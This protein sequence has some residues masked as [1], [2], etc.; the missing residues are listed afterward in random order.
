MSVGIPRARTDILMASSELR[1]RVNDFAIRCFRDTAD[2]DYIAAR[3]ACRARLLSQ[4]LWASQQAI[5]KYLKCILLLKRIPPAD[6]KHDLDKAL[7]CLAN[8]DARVELCKPTQEFIRYLDRYGRFR[9]LEISHWGRGSDLLILDRAV[10]EVRRHCTL[11]DIGP[12]HQLV[13]GVEGANNQAARRLLGARYRWPRQAPWFR[14]F[15]AAVAERV[16]W[17][18][19]SKIPATGRLET[20]ASPSTTPANIFVSST[21]GE[22]AA[23]FTA[24]QVPDL[25][26]R[27]APPIRVRVDDLARRRHL[28]AAAVRALGWLIGLRLD[29]ASGHHDT[30]PHYQVRALRRVTAIWS[31]RSHARSG[32]ERPHPQSHAATGQPCRSAEHCAT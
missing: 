9:Y 22:S 16:C 26:A 15:G 24:V 21:K 1:W 8:A 23:V 28:T 27:E 7:K 11:E 2:G 4:Y 17:A 30:L 25:T 29:V 12:H 13:E 14:A 31:A 10:R 6:V 18:K 32:P 3:L 19:A 20:F 5:E